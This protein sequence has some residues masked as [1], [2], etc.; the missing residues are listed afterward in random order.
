MM[1]LSMLLMGTIG[2]HYLEGWTFVESL[3]ATVVTL[4]T[5]GYGDFSRPEGG[6]RGT[7]SSI[8]AVLRNSAR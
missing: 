2:F 5:V 7:R 6:G 4:S 8:F 1:L 3:Y